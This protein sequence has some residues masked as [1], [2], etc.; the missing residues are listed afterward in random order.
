MTLEKLG[1][2]VSA[3][4]MKRK[5]Y[6]HCTGDVGIITPTRISEIEAHCGID[7]CQIFRVSGNCTQPSVNDSYLSFFHNLLEP[8]LSEAI[9]TTN[10]PN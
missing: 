5:Q 3:F 1:F 4:M 8:P 7:A 10:F 6:G 2:T 9:S